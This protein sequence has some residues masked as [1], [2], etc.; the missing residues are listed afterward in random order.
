MHRDNQ[1]TNQTENH[2]RSATG[3][4][5]LDDILGGGFIPHRLYLID[6]D[7]GAGKTTLSLQYLIEGQRV[8]EKGL[9]VTLSE[10]REELL[11]VANSHGWSLDGIEIVELVASE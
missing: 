5:G 9:Y 6:G 10:T 7:P 3:I 2:P 8:G 1:M 11:E 4:A